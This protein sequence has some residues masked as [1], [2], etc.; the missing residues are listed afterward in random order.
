[1]ENNVVRQSEKEHVDHDLTVGW[2]YNS[3]AGFKNYSPNCSVCELMQSG[4]LPMTDFSNI[5]MAPLV[6][7]N[8]KT[9]RQTDRRQAG[10]QAD[11]FSHLKSLIA[12]SS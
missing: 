9:F 6:Q 12:P 2:K 5:Y 7:T 3:L 10:R 8:T 4:N 1:M 11:T